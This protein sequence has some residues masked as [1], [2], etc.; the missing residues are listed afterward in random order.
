MC[1]ICASMLAAEH[2]EQAGAELCPKCRRFPLDA[3]MP[4]DLSQWDY[5]A[6]Q[7]Q[8]ATEPVASAT[9]TFFDSVLDEQAAESS[10]DSIHDEA[11]EETE[12]HEEHEHVRT[13]YHC[14]QEVSGLAE[15]CPVCGDAYLP[16]PLRKAHYA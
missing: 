4:L 7:L 2:T 10:G 3:E 8:D 16:P 14:Y 1:E 5:V 11:A 9:P 6:P 12:E 15:L 13:C